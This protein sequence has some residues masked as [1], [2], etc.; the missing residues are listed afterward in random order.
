MG[1]SKGQRA[2]VAEARAK[3]ALKVGP[4]ATKQL[5]RRGDLRQ[6]GAGARSYGCNVRVLMSFHPWG[7]FLPPLCFFSVSVP[8]D[9][10]EGAPYEGPSRL[11]GPYRGS[12]Q[13]ICDTDFLSFFGSSWCLSPSSPPPGCHLRLCLYCCRPT[14][15]L[16]FLGVTRYHVFGSGGYHVLGTLLRLRAPML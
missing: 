6:A 11:T 7:L 4:K 9:L 15:F 10:G 1:L 14:F 8:H 16:L 12:V 2:K 13:V 3:A 5:Q